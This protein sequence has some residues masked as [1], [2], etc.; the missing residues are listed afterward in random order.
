[1]AKQKRTSH[2]QSLRENHSVAEL[3]KRIDDWAKGNSDDS[4]ADNMR[5][6]LARGSC[7]GK[8]KVQPKP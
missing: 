3:A 8:R 4:H 7:I 2:Q 1:M 5:Q 6:L